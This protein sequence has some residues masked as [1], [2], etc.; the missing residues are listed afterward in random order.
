MADIPDVSPTKPIWPTRP[1]ERA[2]GRRE[3][4][5]EGEREQPAKQDEPADKERKDKDDG[6][7]IDEYV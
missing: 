3:P 4:G 1:D 7:L 6:H 5:P 2:P